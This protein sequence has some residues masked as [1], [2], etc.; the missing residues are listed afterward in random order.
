MNKKANTVLFLIGA[1]VFNIVTTIVSF[2]ALIVVYGRLVAP[3]LPENV[4]AWGLPVVFVSAIAI[5]FVAYRFA[6]KLFLKKFKAEDV[7]GSFNSR[8]KGND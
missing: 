7:F 1:T 5:A 6:M 4:V 2:L 8:R 3:V